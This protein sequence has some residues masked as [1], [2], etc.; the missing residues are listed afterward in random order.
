MIKS[1]EGAFY[2]VLLPLPEADTK[3]AAASIKA[4]AVISVRIERNGSVSGTVNY[5]DKIGAA[6]KPRRLCVSRPRTAPLPFPI[7][8]LKSGAQLFPS[9]KISLLLG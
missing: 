2:F 4:A 1:Y 7:G 8:I 3:N 5:A 9:L 6:V